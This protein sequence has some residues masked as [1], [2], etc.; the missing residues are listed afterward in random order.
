M[1]FGTQSDMES[2]QSGLDP[3][4]ATGGDVPSGFSSDMGDGGSAE[5]FNSFVTG[6]TPQQAYTTGRGATA[7][8]PYPESFFS[9]MFGAENV[10]YT[11][12]L[13]GGQ[14]GLNRVAE[15]NDL[16]FRQAIGLP[17]LK[18]GKQYQAGDYYI[19]QDT[20]MGTVKPIPDMARD[21][22][23]LMPGGGIISNFIPQKGLPENDPRYR[24]IMEEREK[25]AND[26]NVFDSVL[27]FVKEKTGFGP[28]D[29]GASLAASS[30]GDG[31]MRVPDT[32]TFDAFGNVTGSA[33]GI[34]GLLEGQEAGKEMKDSVDQTGSNVKLGPESFLKNEIIRD[35]MYFDSSPGRMRAVF[36]EEVASLL[37]G[38]TPAEAMRYANIT[39]P[40][41]TG[42]VP[43][44]SDPLLSREQQI[45]KD[46][47]IRRAYRNYLKG[48]DRI[49]ENMA[50]ADL[51]DKTTPGT[52]DYMESLGFTRPF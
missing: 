1:D 47:E 6:L 32:R 12:I 49:P 46:V 39:K 52:T 38:L 33:K 44:Y 15:I 36:G 14:A 7:T 30:T 22:M 25:S 21:M 27:D 2:I 48:T 41:E 17:S 13:G 9:R 37:G 20:N 23:S 28:K 19:G 3:S 26:P 35:P 10:N 50:F 42:T 24:A 40:S 45:A 5:D 29:S 34:M 8:N 18:T 43:P 11:N 51:Y 4:G 16:R 31:Q